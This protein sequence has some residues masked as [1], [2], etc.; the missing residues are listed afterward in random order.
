M[1]GQVGIDNGW[2]ARPDPLVSEV[3]LLAIFCWPL[4][5]RHPYLAE[6]ALGANLEESETHIRERQQQE[7]RLTAGWLGKNEVDIHKWLQMGPVFWM[8]V[9][10]CCRR[11][12]PG[13]AR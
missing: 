10:R 2:R 7:L 11:T 9:W 8:N 5:C 13:V 6:V 12:Q 4:S 1:T 3:A